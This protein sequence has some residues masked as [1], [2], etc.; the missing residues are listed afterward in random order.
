[1]I[2]ESRDLRE[3]RNMLMEGLYD[4]VLN[5]SNKYKGDYKVIKEGGDRDL[6]KELGSLI[7]EGKGGSELLNRGIGKG[8]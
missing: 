7:N 1:E 8:E 4:D 5:R 3:S 2:I 6:I